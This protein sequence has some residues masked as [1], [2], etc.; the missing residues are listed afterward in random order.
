MSSPHVNLAELTDL[1][2]GFTGSQAQEL[3]RN[4]KEKADAVCGQSRQGKSC[5]INAFAGEKVA[6][7]GAT[8]VTNTENLRLEHPRNPNLAFWDV[9]GI[10]GKKFQREN[11]FEKIESK[12]NDYDFFLIVTKDTFS[13]DTLYLAEQ[14]EKMGK[15]YFLIRT[16]IDKSIEDAIEEGEAESEEKALEMIKKDLREGTNRPIYLIN[17]KKMF[18]YD[19]SKLLEDCC[20]QGFASQLRDAKEQAFLLTVRTSTAAMHQKKYKMFK[21]RL[22]IIALKSAVGGAVLISGVGCVV[23]MRLI[24]EEVLDYVYT[25]GLDPFAIFELE[26]ATGKPEGSL[27]SRVQ[28]MAEGRNRLINMCREKGDF[29]EKPT[30]TAAIVLAKEALPT[31]ARSLSIIATSEVAETTAKTVLPFIGSVIGAVLS[32]TSTRIQ[33]GLILEEVKQIADEI[34]QQ[35]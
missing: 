29:F 25:F 14:I 6:R 19:M 15:S 26:K 35:I 28:R 22:N 27:E 30:P 5:L 3:F 34:T 9:P 12:Q 32:F 4:L 8:R 10:D 31:I 21:S 11:Y 23:D 1:I 33:L 17:N 18:Q 7:V 20:N 24:C 13:S 16:H 2:R